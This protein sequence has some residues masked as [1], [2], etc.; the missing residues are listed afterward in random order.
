MD[1]LTWLHSGE[2]IICK[3]ITPFQ[4]EAIVITKNYLQKSFSNEDDG[5]HSQMY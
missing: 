5:V 2:A 3:Q 4:K 1:N